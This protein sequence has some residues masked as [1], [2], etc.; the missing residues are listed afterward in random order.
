MPKTA[1]EMTVQEWQAYDP[2]AAAKRVTEQ[3]KMQIAKRRRQAWRV[4]RQAAKLLRSEFGATNVVLFGSL[5]HK[6]WFT[7][8]SDIDLAARGIPVDRFYGAVA[9]MIDFSSTFKID[10]VDPSDCS[11]RLRQ[12]IDREGI[13]V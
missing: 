5:A 10:L 6:A 13:D 11:P 12:A 4:A 1:S 9:A 2:W 7:L 8:R 3:E